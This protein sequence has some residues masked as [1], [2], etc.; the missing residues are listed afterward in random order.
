MVARRWGILWRRLEVRTPRHRTPRPPPPTRDL[1]SPPSRW[2]VPLRHVPLLIFTVLYLHNL[3]MDYNVPHVNSVFKNHRFAELLRTSDI[4]GE[5][6]R[7][8]DRESSTLR[9]KLM[10]TLEYYGMCRPA[11]SAVRRNGGAAA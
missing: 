5:Q 4:I 7:R 1:H 3:A 2:Q 10:A 6:G 8:R 9:K 11:M